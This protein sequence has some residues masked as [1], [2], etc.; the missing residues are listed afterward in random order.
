MTCEPQKV[1]LGSN[2]KMRILAVS[3]LRTQPLDDLARIVTETKPDLVVYAGDDV[4]RLG[5][6]P[7]DIHVG[8]AA[9]KLERKLLLASDENPARSSPGLILHREKSEQITHGPI[10]G[11][12]LAIAVGVQV[13]AKRLAQ[14]PPNDEA[15][16]AHDFG[17]TPQ[18]RIR[19]RRYLRWLADSWWVLCVFQKPRSPKKLLTALAAVPHGLAGVL[20][21][22]CRA[23]HRLVLEQPGF[24][25]LH[26]EPLIIDGVALLGLQGAPADPG[27]GYLLR[28]IP[29]TQRHLEQQLRA[30]EGR[31]SILISHAPPRGVLDLAMRFGINHIGCKVVREHLDAGSFAGVICGHVHRCGGKTRTVA[32]TPVINIASHDNPTAPI[33]SA[34]IETGPSGIETVTLKTFHQDRHLSI[35]LPEVGEVRFGRLMAAGLDTIDAVAAASM[36]QLQGPLESAAARVQKH[37]RARLEGTPIV[38]PVA[39]PL[40]SPLLFLDTEYSSDG[41]DAPWLVGLLPPGRDEVLQ[42]VQLDPDKQGE[43]IEW[44][45]ATLDQHSDG[46]LTTWGASDRIVLLKACSRLGITPPEWLELEVYWL[47][48]HLE[49]KHRLTLPTRGYTLDAVASLFGYHWSVPELE[50]RL[51]G[52]MYAQHLET[53]RLL[54]LEMLEAYNADDVRAMAVVERAYR[55]ISGDMLATDQALLGRQEHQPDHQGRLCT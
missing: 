22:D 33:E 52:Q 19:P 4:L 54:P 2:T 24:H 23:E 1:P 43:T 37:A 49:I 7:D 29:E 55:A 27:I 35:S 36:E 44:L 31:P 9:R 6:V 18:R 28:G 5:G 39:R 51:V 47:N 25:N 3:D 26:A 38:N 30:T 42:H 12:T 48:L 32:G 20:G 41:G 10:W 46:L 50:G 13:R 14:R 53:G 15:I 8:L 16:Q 21:N 40:P 34:I 11:A 45:D 17:E